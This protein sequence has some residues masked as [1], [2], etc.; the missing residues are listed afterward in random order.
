MIFGHLAL[1]MAAVFAGAALYINVAEHPARL[2]L[3]D[4]NLLKQW[5][6]SYGA[7]FT[8][9]SSLAVASFALGLAAAWMTTDWRWIAGAGLIVANWPFTLIVI[10]PVNHKLNAIAESEAGPSSRTLLLTWGR[11]HAV[12]TGLGFAAVLAYLWALN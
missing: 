6:P 8:M 7:G 1:V 12:R 5:K 2:T 4:K 10:M 9:Q 11:L 3:D